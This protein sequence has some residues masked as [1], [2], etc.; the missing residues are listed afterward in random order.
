MKTESGLWDVP[1][2]AGLEAHALRGMKMFAAF[3]TIAPRQ[4]ICAENVVVNEA[5]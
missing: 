5:G 2:S 1:I 4:A 3:E